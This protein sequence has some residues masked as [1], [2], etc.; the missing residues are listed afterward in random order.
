MFGE[1]SSQSTRGCKPLNQVKKLKVI[2]ITLGVERFAVKQKDL[3][4]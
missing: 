2:K 3:Y 4:M 1:V